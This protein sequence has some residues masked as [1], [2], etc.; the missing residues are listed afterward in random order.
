MTDSVTDRRLRRSAAALTVLALAATGCSIKTDTSSDRVGRDGVKM[1]PGVTETTITLGALTDLSGVYASLGKSIVNAQQLWVEQTNKV[2]GICGRK[3]EIKVK[4]H[5]YDVQKGVAA[6]AE[7]EPD[8]AMLTQVIG[9]PVVAA[10]KQEIAGKK[11]LTLPLGWSSTLLGQNYIQ[12]V[13]P[14]YDIDMINAVD[15]LTRKA[16]LTAG[17]AIGH[18]Y[19]EGEYGENALAGSKYAADKQGYRIVEQKIKATDTD[20]GAQVTAL[21]QAGVKAILVS[22]GPKQAASLVGLAAAQ[23]LTVPVVGSAPSFAP[24][25]L[26]SAAGPA[27]EKMF[28]LISGYPAP[29]SDTSRMRQLVQDYRAKYPDAPVDSGVISGWVSAQVAAEALTNA[30]S[31][32]D[33][34]REGIVAAHRSQKALNVLDVPLDF[35]DA[36]KPS[37]YGSF[38]LKPA[39]SATGGLVVAEP[40]HE[41]A[42]TRGYPLPKG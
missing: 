18:V 39:K 14:T 42:A 34:T 36:A 28:Y 22:A 9:S 26:D 29:S 4:D 35:T 10:L 13:G 2:G 30:C 19:F 40:A 25:L 6:F 32:R 38:V 21:K 7:I 31:A 23:G 11:I 16:G 5:G 12:V 20:L 41:V 3:V 24:Q 1:G 33:L 27:L 17:D 8:S 37:A 15:F